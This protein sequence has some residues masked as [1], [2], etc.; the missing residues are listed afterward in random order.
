MKVEFDPAL[1]RMPS[2]LVCCSS[3]EDRCA[4][5]LHQIR[6]DRPVAIALFHH[7][8]PNPR[9]ERRHL[10]MVEIARG[11]GVEVIEVPHTKS[12]PGI[13]MAREVRQLTNALSKYRDIEIV[14]DISVLTRIH[15]FMLFRWFDDMGYWDRLRIGYC[16]P[17][18]YFISKHIPLSFGLHAFRKIPSI[19][20]CADCR[21]STH[22]MLFLGYEGDRSLAAFEHIQPETTTLVVPKPP[23]RPEWIGWTERFNVEIIG[24]VGRDQIVHVDPID[25]SAVRS[26][27]ERK[28]GDVR[29]GSVSARVIVPTGT[30][31]QAVGA[32]MY[33][34]DAVDQLS[35]IYARPIRY[36]TDLYPN[37]IGRVW[38][39]K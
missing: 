30:K 35:I 7:D 27:M 39:I 20:A 22:L 16:E 31:P 4:G 8:D 37:G 15:M 12:Q 28:F 25:P 9:R 5:I 18:S 1:F 6:D 17:R 29:H 34:R 14:L 3:H 26:M 10:E 24:L 36:N 19:A 2:L 38:R 13:S 21:R 23:Y 11:L 32:Y 33:T